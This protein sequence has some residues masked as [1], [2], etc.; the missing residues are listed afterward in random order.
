VFAAHPVSVP[1]AVYVGTTV[2]GW[3][4]QFCVG[5]PRLIHIA[6][7]ST[8]IDPSK[9]FDAAG[10]DVPHVGT[11]LPTVTP[12]FA[13]VP[14]ITVASAGVSVSETPLVTPFAICKIPFNSVIETAAWVKDAIRVVSVPPDDRYCAVNVIVAPSKKEAG[15]PERSHNTNLVPIAWLKFDGGFVVVKVAPLMEVPNGFAIVTV[16]VLL[17]SIKI[18]VI[19]AT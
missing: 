19:T 17:V 16:S 2:G 4:P 7:P 11:E 8:V 18:P 6:L 12:G 15:V 10:T 9:L 13:S 5:V 14:D 3:M 1:E